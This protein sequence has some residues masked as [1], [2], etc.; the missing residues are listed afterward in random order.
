MTW[1]LGIGKWHYFL[2]L[3]MLGWGVKKEKENA[4][5]LSVFSF[6]TSR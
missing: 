1:L 4:A 6:F 3:N 2:A 5:L